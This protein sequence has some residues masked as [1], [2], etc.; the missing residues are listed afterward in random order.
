MNTA[1]RRTLQNVELYHFMFF[2]FSLSFSSVFVFRLESKSN[3]N[4][5][6]TAEQ[7]VW[8]DGHF[9]ILFVFWIMQDEDGVECFSYP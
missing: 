1:V 5:N 3:T 4:G 6:E 2:C 7:D 9:I 8:M